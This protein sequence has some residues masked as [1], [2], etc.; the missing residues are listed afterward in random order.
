MR[1]EFKVGDRVEFV[2]EYSKHAGLGDRGIVKA[3]MPGKSPYADSQGATQ[4]CSVRMDSGEE[5]RAF[6]VRMKLVEAVEAAPEPQPV[7]YR[8]CVGNS[9]GTTE[10]PTQDAAKQAALLHGNDGEEFS[11]WEVVKVADYRV[12]VSKELEEV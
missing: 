8:I 6:N 1:K 5:V 4:L 10:Y 9:I 3:V 11:I 12:K 7:T 2:E